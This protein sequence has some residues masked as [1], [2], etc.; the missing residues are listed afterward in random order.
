LYEDKDFN[1]FHGKGLWEERKMIPIHLFR[2]WYEGS[3]SLQLKSTGDDRFA[4]AL[5]AKYGG[6]KFYDIDS[7]LNGFPSVV[8]GFTLEDNCCVLWKLNKDASEK[9]VKGY[10]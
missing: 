1:Q 8:N 9:P 5:T 10:G 2:A 3:E 7:P 6:L 4:A